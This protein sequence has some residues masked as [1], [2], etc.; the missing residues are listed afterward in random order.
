MK[1][2]CE[3][4]GALYIAD[5]VQTGLMRTGEMWGVAKAGI[6]PDIMVIGKGI[7]GGMY[8][9]ACTVLSEECS[10]WLKEDGFGHI[11]T[12]GG[13]ELGCVVGLKVLEI[14]ERPE[15]RSMVHYIADR[16]GRGLRAIQELYPDWFVGI[17]QD[18]V[19]MGLEFE[20]PEG[21]K[22]VM[23]H[24]YENGVW[25][26]FRRSTRGCCSSNR[27]FCSAP[28][29]STRCW[30]EP[31]SRSARRWPRRAAT[32]SRRLL[33]EGHGA[34]GRRRPARPMML[35][36]AH[37]AATAF[38]EFDLER[39]R[40]IVEAVAEEAYQTPKGMP[41]GPSR[42]PAWEPSKVIKNE[43]CSKGVVDW[44]RDDFVSARVDSDAR[45]VE[46][47]RPAGVVLALTFDQPDRDCLLQGAAIA[48]DSQRRR[49]Q[50]TSLRP[51][52]LRRRRASPG[53]RG[54]GRRRSR[55]LR[56]GRGGADDSPDRG[57][58]ERSDDRRDRRH[59][60]H[61]R[62]PSRISLGEPRLGRGARQRPGARGPHGRSRRGGPAPDGFE[63]LRQLDPLYERVV[64]D[65]GGARRRR[66]PEGARAAR[67][68]C[69]R[70]RRTSRPCARRSTP[71]ADARRA[72]RQGRPDAGQEAGIRSPAGAR[73]LVAPFSLV[74]PE[75]PLAREKLFPLLGLVRV[76]DAR[77]GID[78]ARAM[79]RIGGAGHSA[80]IHS[81]DPRTVM[82]Y[83]AAVQVLRV[84]VNVGA[85]T[86]SAG[87]GTNLAPTMTVGTGFFGRS[88]LGENLEPRT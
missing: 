48:D 53:P 67:R 32:A 86:G 33:D 50:P 77:R 47:P 73:V 59:W 15:V 58:D 65:R 57:A 75:E 88:S 26:I 84:A 56:A 81:R 61:G 25:A 74:V 23:K 78:A 14:C 20:D 30:I 4:F 39:T 69:A 82:A 76:P 80:T 40:R 42:R 27:A 66:L 45:I 31:R 34:R 87:I 1:E 18:G 70:P 49:C 63:E 72:G 46:I 21:A 11:S 43:A 2:L 28:N 54:G 35:Q 83:G 55:R 13:A 8:P 68:P 51:G 3:R 44:W 16:F 29:W 38:A 85:S 10:A 24:L 9:I 60:R 79:L 12:G 37:W 19:V 36:R 5:E 62:R 17:R 6:E 52:G 41:S 64:R 71:R 7:T 22:I